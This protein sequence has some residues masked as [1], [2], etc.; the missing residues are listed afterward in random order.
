[1]RF[2]LQCR[3]AVAVAAAV[4][5]DELTQAAERSRSWLLSLDKIFAKSG[6]DRSDTDVAC[7]SRPMGQ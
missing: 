4:R 5:H 1:M 2:T 7:Y 6:S 3:C